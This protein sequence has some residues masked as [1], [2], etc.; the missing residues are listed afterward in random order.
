VLGEEDLGKATLSDLAT[1]DEVADKA[2]FCRTI[3][4]M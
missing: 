4:P 1:D 2:I 3:P